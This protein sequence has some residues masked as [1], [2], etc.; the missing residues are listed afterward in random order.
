MHDLA[1]V[2]V[3]QARGHVVEDPA[4]LLLGEDLDLVLLLLQRVLAVLHLQVEVAPLDP[5]V[6]VA[7]DLGVFVHR[8]QRGQGLGLVDAVAVHRLILKAAFRALYR[9]Q[10]AVHLIEHLVDS[11]KISA[12]DHVDHLEVLVEA[13]RLFVRLLLHVVRGFPAVLGGVLEHLALVF[14]VHG[15]SHHID[16]P[17]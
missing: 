17:V 5:G 1:A 11:S 12:A 14:V 7:H 9:V 13:R 4:D 2:Q 15:R 10:V 8:A 6:V 16:V 3:L